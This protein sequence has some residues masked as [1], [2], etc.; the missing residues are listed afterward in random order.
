M[1][2]TYDL[3]LSAEKIGLVRVTRQGLYYH[4]SCRCALSGEMM[5]HLAVNW[6]GGSE[7]LGLLMPM[8]GQFGIETR[9]PA[10]RLGQGSLTFSLQPK[11][12]A[13][14]GLFVPICADEPF[15]YLHRLEN[16]YLATQH[17]QLGIILP[18]E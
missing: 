15:A 6:D 13:V 10:K 5:Y 4:F 8:D 7:N 17:Q 9:L 2:G 1:E 11:H 3:M 16:A 12:R 18:D 14:K